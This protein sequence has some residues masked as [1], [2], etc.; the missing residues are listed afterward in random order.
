MREVGMEIYS[1]NLQGHIIF[2]VRGALKTNIWRTI[3]AGV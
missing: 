2:L 1:G 3:S